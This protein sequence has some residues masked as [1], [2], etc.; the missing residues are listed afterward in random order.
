MEDDRDDL[1]IVMLTFGVLKKV[2]TS[3]CTIYLTDIECW[4]S[5]QGLFGI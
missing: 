3:F 4:D 2:S 5:P 1:D